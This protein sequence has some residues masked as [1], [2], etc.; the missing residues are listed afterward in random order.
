MGSGGQDISALFSGEAYA[1]RNAASQSLCEGSQVS[2]LAEVVARKE[3]TGSSDAGLNLVCDGEDV[4]F[5]AES[6]D[7]VY[8]FLL[9]R[10]N[11][12]LALNVLEHYGADRVV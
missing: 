3:L 4:L 9:E 10:H 12:A 5:S 1:D 11:A 6:V 7:L 8:K 2:L